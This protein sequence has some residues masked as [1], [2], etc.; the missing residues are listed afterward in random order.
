[1]TARTAL[2]RIAAFFRDDRA[3]SSAEFALVV[4]VFL[5]IIF[6][7]I[8][9]AIMM[10][11]ITQMHYAA[12]RAARCLSVDVSD[13]CPVGTIDAYAKTYYNGPGMAGL[14]FTP[15]QNQPCGNRVVGTGSYELFTGVAAT[16]VNLSATAC[17]PVDGIS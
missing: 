1:M 7:T 10:S 15:T 17:Y 11:A 13:D 5:I 4:P 16:S 9:G 3:A 14:T 8:S 12:E 6:S 2:A